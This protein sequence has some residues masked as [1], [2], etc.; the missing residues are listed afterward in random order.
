MMQARR[1]GETAAAARGDSPL[2]AKAHILMT[3]CPAFQRHAKWLQNI[4]TP[5]IMRDVELGDTEKGLQ[6][7]QARRSGDM[8]AAARGDSLRPQGSTADASRRGRSVSPAR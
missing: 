5:H 8:A 1:S 3:A 6:P 4:L 2:T 7:M